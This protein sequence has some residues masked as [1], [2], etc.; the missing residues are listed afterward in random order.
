MVL[1]QRGRA[2]K[3]LDAV[4]PDRSAGQPGLGWNEFTGNLENAV[5]TARHA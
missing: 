1:Q 4:S 3:K 2:V 5:S